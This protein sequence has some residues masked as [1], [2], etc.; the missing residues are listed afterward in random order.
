MYL[1]VKVV[2]TS[3]IRGRTVPWDRH[4]HRSSPW[5]VPK[6][7]CCWNPSAACQRRHWTSVAVIRKAPAARASCVFGGADAAVPIRCPQ[8]ERQRQ[9]W[10]RPREVAPRWGAHRVTGIR[11][12]CSMRSPARASVSALS[13]HVVC[14]TVLAVGRLLLV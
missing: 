10:R 3:L 2:G 6:R 5:A 7:P 12:A 8:T 9:A 13:V 1:R 14:Q 11:N 4:P